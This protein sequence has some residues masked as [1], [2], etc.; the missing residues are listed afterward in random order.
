[1]NNFDKALLASSVFPAAII[2]AIIVFGLIMF[3]NSH[4]KIIEKEMYCEMTKLWKENKHLPEDERP[5]WPEYKGPCHG[6]Q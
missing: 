5:G 2:I 3:S 1:M 6:V 4:K